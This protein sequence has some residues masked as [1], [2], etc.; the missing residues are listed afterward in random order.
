MNKK[1]EKRN[2]CFSE[3]R[4]DV[5]IVDSQGFP[6]QIRNLAH[7]LVVRRRFLLAAHALGHELLDQLFALLRM[8]ID[9]M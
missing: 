6:L 5:G 3:Q 1:N 4:F 8:S 2:S 9:R 7:Q